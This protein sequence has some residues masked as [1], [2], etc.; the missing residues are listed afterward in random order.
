MSAPMISLILCVVILAAIITA[1]VLVAKW[2][3]EIKNSLESIE[4]KLK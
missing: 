1:I 4:K 3:G 2:A